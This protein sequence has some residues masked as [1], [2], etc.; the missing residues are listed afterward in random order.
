[1]KEFMITKSSVANIQYLVSNPKSRPAM[2]N[3]KHEQFLFT[4]PVKIDEKFFNIKKNYFRIIFAQRDFFLKTL[5]MYNCGGPLAFNVKDTEQIG[6]QNKN[7]SIT[8]STQ[9]TFNH[10]A[11]FAKSFVEYT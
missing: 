9:K 11:Q 8:I 4:F 7:Y 10:S 5:T 2:P 6:R 3:S 1:M